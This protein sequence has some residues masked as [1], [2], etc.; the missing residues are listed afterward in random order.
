MPQVSQ[1]TTVFLQS[2]NGIITLFSG[3]SLDHRLLPSLSCFWFLWFV[4]TRCVLL[5]F[6]WKSSVGRWGQAPLIYSWWF[7]TGVTF[8]R[9][10]G[11]SAVLTSSRNFDFSSFPPSLP[12]SH[13]PT[14][15]FASSVLQ[16][17]SS[18]SRLKIPPSQHRIEQ[19]CGCLSFYLGCLTSAMEWMYNLR[20]LLR[21]YSGFSAIISTVLTFRTCEHGRIISRLFRY[22]WFLASSAAAWRV[23]Y[24]LPK[25]HLAQFSVTLDRSDR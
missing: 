3:K 24:H 5:F 4:V 15:R 11:R 7:G 16:I 13:I 25:C 9:K 19:M 2:V 10:H 12:F 18:P 8:F 17:V 22:V 20:S 23:F 1:K 14:N 21:W 6:E